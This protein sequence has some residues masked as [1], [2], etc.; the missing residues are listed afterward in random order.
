[1]A[2]GSLSGLFV[3]RLLGEAGPL[4]LASLLDRSE[5]ADVVLDFGFGVS[6]ELFLR[7]LVEE[8][9][10]SQNPEGRFA[11]TDLGQQVLQDVVD[12]RIDRVIQA[13][14]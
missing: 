13:A 8:G 9:L 5:R 14:A 3:L 2:L 12:D 10:I 11:V 4:S 6:L 1:M 7:S